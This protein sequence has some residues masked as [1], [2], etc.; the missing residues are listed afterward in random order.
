MNPVSSPPN[1]ALLQTMPPPVALH[2]SCQ[3]RP[4]SVRPALSHPRYLPKK[5]PGFI[6]KDFRFGKFVEISDPNLLVY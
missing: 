1:D 4:Q 3:M 2:S 5:R 6:M